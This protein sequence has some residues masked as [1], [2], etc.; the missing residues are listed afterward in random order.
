MDVSRLPFLLGGEEGREGGRRASGNLVLSLVHMVMT[1][2]TEK[3]R[4]RDSI[5]VIAFC[6]CSSSCLSEWDTVILWLNPQLC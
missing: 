4:R 5:L 3:A 1:G 6:L 2:N